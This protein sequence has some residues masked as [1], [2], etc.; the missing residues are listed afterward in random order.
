MKRFVFLL[1]ALLALG[2]VA[3]AQNIQ[4]IN[5]TDS[6]ATRRT[7]ENANFT[8]LVSNHV[9]KGGDTMAG[10][11][12]LAADPT[13]A[14]GAATK[15]YVDTGLSNGLSSLNAS[16]LVSGTVPP[17]R[18]PVFGI[19][20]ANHAPGA[21]PDPGATAGTTRVL[22]ENGW[23]NLP[24]G[25]VT[26]VGLSAPSSLFSV[27]GSPVT[28][29]GTLGL[30]F[31]NWNANQFFAGPTS[32]GAAAPGPRSIVPADLPVF[33]ASGGSHAAGIVPDPGSTAG[34][35]KYLREDA[36]FTQ[37]PFSSLTGTSNVALTNAAITWTGPGHI[38][39]NSVTFN[40]PLTVNQGNGTDAFTFFRGQ[41]SSPTGNLIRIKN[42]AGTTD[43]FVVDVTGAITTGIGS[44]LT[45]LN[46]SNVSSGTLAN[47]R[48]SAQVVLNNQGNAFSTGLQD[49]SAAT[50]KVPSSAGYAP[51]TSGLFG[52]NSTTNQYVGAPNGVTAV[53]TTLGNGTTG[54]G[55][56]IVLG[57]GPSISSPS[58]TTPTITGALGGNLDFGANALEVEIANDTTTGT[59]LS[60]VA[61]LGGAPSK[62]IITA[63]T[64][65]A[66]AVGIVTGGAGTSSNARI[67]VR[68]QCSCVFDNATTAG[69]Y[70]I[71]SST[72]AGDCH[73]SGSSYPSSGQV[74][75]RVL[76]TNGS[77]GTYSIYLF[78]PETR[79]ASAG[80][81]PPA[82]STNNFQYNAGGGAFGGASNFNVSNNNPRLVSSAAP[83]SPADGEH[84]Y[85]SSHLAQ[86]FREAGA[87]LY[88]GGALFYS[89]ADNTVS[90]TT[91]ETD[92]MSSI[93]GT[94]TLPANFFAAGTTIK[95]TLAGTASNANTVATARVKAKLGANVVF[96][97]GSSGVGWAASSNTFSFTI[98]VYLTCRST[99]VSGSFVGSLLAA[100]PGINNGQAT[101][102]SATVDTT[103][104]QAVDV[105]LTPSASGVTVTLKSVIG[106]RIN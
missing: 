60:K 59:T 44:G 78:G 70:V 24:G 35:L 37:I 20:G 48:L 17:A 100:V 85:D 67:G 42:A 99:G 3:R 63:T 82:G 77:A 64:D 8:W 74:L 46:A 18:L 26:S 10:A 15:H 23:G 66:G 30:A 21:V 45:A 87:V 95:I 12:I 89:T 97:T 5:N 31:V 68:G 79:G 72:T 94:T 28:S 88:Y 29:S 76:S 50:F 25:A 11:L 27:S 47:G 22:F 61:K 40:N 52:Y 103:S 96:D 92:V 81:A 51:T 101:T 62:A 93:S 53:F 104:S 6:L 1:C 9:N 16:N 38:F 33:V 86:A 55:S 105:T 71:L 13:A 65:T 19:S 98:V 84:W 69:D 41:D 83:G 7:K 34:T 75:G 106:E 2:P 49:L 39:N 56:N 32:G 58:I 80:G 73:D 102:N 91:S 90:G 4:T 57:T 43:L 14:N 36:T 54:S